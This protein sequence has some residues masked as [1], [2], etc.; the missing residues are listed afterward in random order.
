MVA[1]SV[2]NDSMPELPL[3]YAGVVLDKDLAG[4]SGIGVQND[5][6]TIG[7]R[8]VD[9]TGRDQLGVIVGQVAAYGVVDT[10]IRCP[11][12]AK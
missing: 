6:L 2:R 1:L 4:I 3:P 8:V 11:S 10:R 9:A 12:S 7:D 5:T